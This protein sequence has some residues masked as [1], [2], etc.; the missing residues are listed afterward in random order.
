[1][2]VEMNNVWSE[3]NVFRSLEF[4]YIPVGF[5]LVYHMHSR[6][7]PGLSFNVTR[8]G[9]AFFLSVVAAFL[10]VCD[11]GWGHCLRIRLIVIVI[12]GFGGSYLLMWSQ[13]VTGSPPIDLVYVIAAAGIVVVA[14]ATTFLRVLKQAEQSK[15]RKDR[16]TEDRLFQ[17]LQL[18]VIGVGA[19]I[20]AF[21][22]HA[23]ELRLPTVTAV[24]YIAA[25]YFVGAGL[26]A[27]DVLG[28]IDELG[29]Q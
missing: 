4:L 16:K 3:D 28:K 26:M 9:V 22:T 6:V 18:I 13:V 29:N 27:L 17:I 7:F 15:G 2:K 14:S 24:A 23:L 25:Y 11:K 19:F 21:M 10:A 5:Y 20:I 8:F 1:M 12:L